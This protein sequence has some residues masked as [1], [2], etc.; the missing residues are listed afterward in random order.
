MTDIHLIPMDQINDAALPRDRAVLDPDAQQAL[1]HSIF[2]STL[3]FPIEVFALP[4]PTETHK[5]GLISGLRRLDACR[6]LHTDYGSP[7][8]IAAF[9]RSP[10]TVPEA[11]AAMVEENEIR[12]DV[13][14]WDQARI[15]LIAA[16]EGIFGSTEDAVRVLFPHA[17]RMK[18]TR[19]CA[20][21]VVVREMEGVLKN[22]QTLNQRQLLRISSAINR[23]MLDVLHL[24]LQ[25]GLTKTSEH[26]WKLMEPYLREAEE[27]DKKLRSHSSEPPRPR[28]MFRHKNQFVVWREKTKKGYSMH[29]RGKE[30]HSGL[31]DG[32]FDEIERWFSPVS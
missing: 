14:P 12:A 22:P 29:F 2:T 1:A 23:G 8:T 19:I 24:A 31:M 21:A 5:Y 13:S 16:D 20:V 10:K 25:H 3:R 32:V 18:R 28:R 6:T 17:D 11:V 7:A 9:I 27:E 26:Q 30:M 15:A 4:E